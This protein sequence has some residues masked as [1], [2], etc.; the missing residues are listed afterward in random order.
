MERS[1]DQTQPPEES[2]QEAQIRLITDSY[3]EDVGLGPDGATPAT[4]R[5]LYRQG[6]LLVRDE[7]LGAANRLLWGDDA[8]PLPP[9]RVRGVVLGVS[10]LRLRPNMDALVALAECRKSLPPGAAG[11]DMVISIAGAAGHC[12]ATEPDPLPAGTA[13]DPWPAADR[14]AGEGVRV[15]VVDTGLDST[16]TDTHA[17]LTGVEGEPDPA[18]RPGGQLDQYAGHGTF[19]A[20]VVRSVAPRCE[21]YVQAA[22]T[23]MGTV[24]ESELVERLDEVLTN[25]QPDIITLSAGTETAEATGLLSFGAF[26]ATRLRRQKGVALVAAAGNNA[27]R[28]PFWPAA[29]DGTVSVGALATNWRS[30]ASFSDF[31][32][33]VDVY[34]PG[35]DLINAFPVGDYTY[36]EPPRQGTTE[37]FDGM[38]RWSG[39]SF[40][41]PL[42]AGLIA[43]RMSMT[44][45]NGR[46]AADALLQF[47][48]QQAVPG[49]GA[50]LRPGDAGASLSSTMR[51][52]GA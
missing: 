8:E 41:T 24:I 22:F 5:Y 9:E 37:H 31:G 10:L 52:P 25:L 12:P 27:D 14:A 43:A 15:V 35:E 45:E 42:V 28:G 36:Q 26:V 47:A 6:Y 33:W 7:Y 34:A 44:G 29:M 11:L 48:R 20:G 18:I 30:R 19:I 46:E 39:T 16:A 21:V 51:L 50:T 17:W 40:S 13:P 32:G 2:R 1:N 4:A 49:V 23:T 38:A 3:G